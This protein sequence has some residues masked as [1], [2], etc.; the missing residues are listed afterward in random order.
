MV[1][2]FLWNDSYVTTSSWNTSSLGQYVLSCVNNK[3]E[4]VWKRDCLY[5]RNRSIHRG[6]D[7]TSF[8]L[9]GNFKF[10]EKGGGNAQRKWKICLVLASNFNEPPEASLAD[11]L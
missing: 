4:N 1:K 6:L 10:S 2:V 9:A 7:F 8:L 11:L 5:F 3:I